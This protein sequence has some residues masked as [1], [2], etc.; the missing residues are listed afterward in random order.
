MEPKIYGLK[1]GQGNEGKLETQIEKKMY[2]NNRWASVFGYNM[3][4]SHK[5]N[6]DSQIICLLWQIQEK[7]KKTTKI[8]V[9]SAMRSGQMQFNLNFG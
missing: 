5:L 7:K 2:I 8:Y 4:D 3:I 1:E 6:Y 9:M